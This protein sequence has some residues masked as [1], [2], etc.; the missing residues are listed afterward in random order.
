MHLV[1]SF[2]LNS[3]LRIGKPYIYEKHFPLSFQGKYI[4]LQPFGKFESKKYD[5]WVETLEI[6]G[7]ILQKNKIKIVRIGGANEPE[8]Y[9]S[10]NLSGKTNYNQTAY[11]INNSLLHL[12]VDSSGVHLASGFGKKIVAL[13][14]IIP[15]SCA[16]PYWSNKE[17]V[18]IL[19]PDRDVDE[20]CSY[21]PIE[22]PKTINKIKPEKIA[23]SV[24][25]LLGIEFNYPFK[26]IYVGKNFHN[27]KIELVPVDVIK[28]ISQFKVESL[29]V[30]MDSHFN[31][32]VL[33]K[34]L[35][36]VPCSIVS[37]NP[38]DMNLLL[39]LRSRI[40]ELIFLIDK[41][42]DTDYLKELKKIGIKFFLISQNSKEET[43]NLK[44]KYLDIGS[45]FLKEKDEEAIKKIKENNLKNIFFKSSSI[46]II[47]DKMY[48]SSIDSPENIP[49][50]KVR[51]NSPMPIINEESFWENLDDY[52][53]LEKI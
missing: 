14:N 23:E 31:E 48:M 46:S 45:F 24:C 53:I 20:K 43:N 3:G 7:P 17:D 35:E 1:E 4:T 39:R 29:I 8:I 19:E 44:L 33:A 47:K 22:N 28:D 6:L 27:R 2:A 40:T 15:P 30:R 37:K 12:G 38:I 13:Y 10:I 49:L 41:N 9:G 52:I 34:Q 50:E 18:I 5:Y 42:S 36:I 32:K 26:T 21:S 51:G 16:G 11:L 25:K